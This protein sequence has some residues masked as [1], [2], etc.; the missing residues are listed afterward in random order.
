MQANDAR[1]IRVL[2]VAADGVPN[3]SS[4]LVHSLSL[5]KQRM[6]ESASFETPLRR[7]RHDEDDLTVTH[8][9]RLASSRPEA[10]ALELDPREIDA[11]ESTV[12]LPDP[13]AAGSAG[14]VASR[15]AR[16]VSEVV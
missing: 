16:A 7:L 4:Q 11:D 12:R 9:W 3:A 6:A 13:A 8:G 14:D 1:P 5:S 2:E 15:L 10:R